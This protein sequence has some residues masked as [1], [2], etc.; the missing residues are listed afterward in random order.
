MWRKGNI[1][2]ASKSIRH[3]TYNH[4]PLFTPHFRH[5]L[6]YPSS[7]RLLAYSNRQIPDKYT[8]GMFHVEG[9]HFY[10][11]PLATLIRSNREG[12]RMQLRCIL[13]YECSSRVLWSMGEKNNMLGSTIAL[14]S[15]MV[16]LGIQT[17]TMCSDVLGKLGNGPREFFVVCKMINEEGVVQDVMH[18]IGYPVTRVTLV[19]RSNEETRRGYWKTWHCLGGLV[20]AAWRNKREWQASEPCMRIFSGFQGSQWVIKSSRSTVFSKASFG[21]KSV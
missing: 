12:T 2:L 9:E 15:Q 17:N 21:K 18:E 10:P 3:T 16:H 13:E 6:F 14:Y 8:R 19:S 1:Q 11:P 4:R 20:W 5:K 7:N